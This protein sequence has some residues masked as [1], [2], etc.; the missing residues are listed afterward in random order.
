MHSL[1]LDEE[2]INKISPLKYTTLVVADQMVMWNEKCE[3][4]IKTS[5]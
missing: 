1:G 2:T 4:L 5:F 3:G